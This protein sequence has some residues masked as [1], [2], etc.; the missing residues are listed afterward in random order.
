M[1]IGVIALNKQTNKRNGELIS[2]EVTQAQN[3]KLERDL[4]P[5]V[6]QEPDADHRT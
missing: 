6:R 2:I 4:K 3:R 5:E 1:M